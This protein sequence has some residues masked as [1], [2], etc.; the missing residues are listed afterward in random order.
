ML[1]MHINKGL[2][3]RCRFL[4]PSVGAVVRVVESTAFKHGEENAA[5]A[6]GNSAQSPTVGMSALP[7]PSIVITTCGV[8]LCADPGPV[9]HRVSQSLVTG[10]PHQDRDLSARALLALLS[11]LLGYRS[12]PCERPERMVV[13]FLKRPG[14]LREHRGAYDSTDPGQG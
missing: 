2:F 4:L 9:I 14:R 3:D 11:G 5:E 8:V 7:E 12:D 13:S 6:V 10:P 1:R